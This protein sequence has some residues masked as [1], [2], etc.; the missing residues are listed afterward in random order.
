MVVGLWATSNP[1]AP[2]MGRGAPFK[3]KEKNKMIYEI[4]TTAGVLALG[5]LSYRLYEKI[6]ERNSEI[7][8]Y[9]FGIRSA[10]VK[11][12]KTFEQFAPFTKKFTDEEKEKFIFLGCPIDGVIFNQDKIT[13]VE[14]KTGN[15]MLSPKQ[16]GIKNLINQGKVEFK[17]VRY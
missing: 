12:G 16:Q 8:R 11:F 5:Y 15:S 3:L 4:I 17:E 14:I 13:F 2:G 7:K 1:G 6:K 10:Y 9:K